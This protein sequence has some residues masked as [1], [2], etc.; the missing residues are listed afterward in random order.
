[1]KRTETILDE[2]VETRQETLRYEQA[3]TSLAQIEADLVG[4]SAGSATAFFD[5]LK[6]DYDTPKILAEAKKASPSAGGLRKPFLPAEIN[7]AYQAANNVVA[8]SVLT[9]DAY[10][11]GSNEMLEF[12]ADNNSQQKPLLRKDFLTDPYQVA[13]SRQLG[14]SAYLL[15]AALFE[16]QELAE[17]VDAGSVYGIEP[18][19]E[20]HSQE[21][22]DMTLEV[23]ARCIGANSRDLRDFSIDLTVHNLLQQLDETYGRVAESAIRTP[24]YLGKVATFSDAALIGTEFMRARDIP[25]TIEVISAPA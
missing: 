6:V 23:G 5:A 20:V 15:I 4:L 22:L 21:E 18:L 17:L 2:I 3:Q 19:V 10:F 11:R 9:E 16:K 8:I 1:M 14:A 7:K 24:H 25:A 12:F 13:Q